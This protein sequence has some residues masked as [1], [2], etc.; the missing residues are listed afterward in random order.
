MHLFKRNTRIKRMHTVREIEGCVVVCERVNDRT[1]YTVWEPGSKATHFQTRVDVEG[2]GMLGRLD[3]RRYARADD[4][5]HALCHDL[6]QRAFP[7]TQ[8]ANKVRGALYL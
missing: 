4:E 3:A 6:I 1:M 7:A 5:L 8:T 2:S